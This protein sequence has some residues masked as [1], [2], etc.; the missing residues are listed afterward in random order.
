[1][2]PDPLHPAVVHLPMAL[3]VLLPVAAVVGLWAARRG[4]R[5]AYAWGVPL[6]L[7][8]LL[9]GSAWVALQTGEGEEERVEAVVSEAAI[10]DHEQAAERFLVLAG[11]VTLIGAA[12]LLGG[13]LGSA[14]RILTTAGAV[15]VLAAG[16]DVGSK[17]GD[18]VYVHGAASAY[19]SDASTAALG[20][21]ERD[22]HG[23]RDGR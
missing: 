19:A 7:A 10:H 1:M 4:S 21:S 8:V 11:V 6:A 23:E 17:G 13:T 9:T 14:A 5:V 20:S 16:V 12:G 3:A 2:L 22:E 15:A 18:L